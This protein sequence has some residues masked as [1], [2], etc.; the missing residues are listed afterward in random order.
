[1]RHQ[2]KSERRPL[3]RALAVE[4]VDGKI[5]E[6]ASVDDM[7]GP[8]EGLPNDRAEVERNRHAH[9]HGLRNRE[10][11]RLDAEVHGVV[12]QDQELLTRDVR[13]HDLEGETILG[14]GLAGHQ[15][16]SKRALA[17]RLQQLSHPAEKDLAPIE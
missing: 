13:R 16:I 8:F 3:W 10:R 1:M 14:V 12:R 4:E 15:E 2:M 6:H 9:P 5:A 17:F 7:A 11:L